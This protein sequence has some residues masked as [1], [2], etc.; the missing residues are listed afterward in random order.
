[1]KNNSLEKKLSIVLGI[2]ENDLNIPTPL[3]VKGMAICLYSLN[4]IIV[5]NDV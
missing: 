2:V 5:W 4:L 3:S 1:M